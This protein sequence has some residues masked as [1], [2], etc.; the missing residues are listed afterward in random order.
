MTLRASTDLLAY[1]ARRLGIEAKQVPWMAGF[2]LGCRPYNDGS[3]WYVTISHSHQLTEIH[4]ILTAIEEISFIVR[5][6]YLRDPQYR[7]WNTRNW[8]NMEGTYT[9]QEGTTNDAGT[10]TNVG[11]SLEG[12]DSVGGGN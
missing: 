2:Y 6:S 8:Y 3:G 1:I 12:H 7:D 10:G 9:A 11:T 4:G 5:E